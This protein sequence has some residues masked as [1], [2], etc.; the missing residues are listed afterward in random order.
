MTIEPKLT[1]NEKQ[2][3]WRTKQINIFYG[4]GRPVFKITEDNQYERKG[5]D[6]KYYT[7]SSK[8]YDFHNIN[9]ISNSNI[10][11]NKNNV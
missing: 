10:D 4:S 7:N 6:C 9:F 11:Q 8:L 5:Y 1:V 2:Q 3:I